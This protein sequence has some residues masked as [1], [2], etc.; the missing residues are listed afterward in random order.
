MVSWG[1][2]PFRLTRRRANPL[3][4]P[5]LLQ[6]DLGPVLPS[7]GGGTRT[8][9]CFARART[10]AACE[11]LVVRIWSPQ[12]TDIG[13]P[14]VYRSR[15]IAVVAATA[16]LLLTA[17]GPAYAQDVPPPENSNAS[18][19]GLGSAFYGQFAVQQRALVAHFVNELE[20]TPG[21]YY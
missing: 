11:V 19:L 5:R 4:L 6:P 3:R 13:G 16:G 7:P 1:R 8:P 2:L 14:L 9:R 15:M 12:L 10:R 20:G 21:E 17:G 18:C